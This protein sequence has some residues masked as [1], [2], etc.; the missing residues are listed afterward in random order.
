[1]LFQGR[2]DRS[3]LAQTEAIRLTQF[4]RHAGAVENEDSFASGADDMDMRGPVIGGIDHDAQSIEVQNG[5]H[6]GCLA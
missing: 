5:R 3:R 1:M 4:W 6:T 2:R